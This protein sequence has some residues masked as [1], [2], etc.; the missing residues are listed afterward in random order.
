MCFH[1]YA[2][3]IA[4]TF[5][6]NDQLLDVFPRLRCKNSS[7]CLANRVIFFHC[8]IACKFKS[9]QQ[10]SSGICFNCYGEVQFGLS[11][12][13]SSS[14]MCFHGYV[15]WTGRTVSPTEEF[16]YLFLRL[17]CMYS[18]GCLTNNAA[19]RCVSTATLPV[20]FELSHQQSS[21]RIYFYGY[22]TCTIRTVSPTGR[23]FDVFPRLSCKYS[24]D[25][26]AN[27]AALGC[28]SAATLHVQ[29]GLSHQKSISGM[30]FHGYAACTVRNVSPTEQ[31]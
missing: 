9:R 27:G 25:C 24:S 4:Q 22:S 29:F 23:L 10:S 31:L 21:S 2:T 13:Q 19:L 5:S 17:R 7:E 20:K 3:Y 26:L 14:G 28:L 1:G 16:W 30:Y 15:A 18:S 11:H 8:Y 6:P 12:Q